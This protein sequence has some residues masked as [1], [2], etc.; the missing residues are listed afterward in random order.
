MAYYG[1]E[2]TKKKKSAALLLLIQL[3]E[4]H[5]Q[6]QQH[7]LHVNFCLIVFCKLGLDICTYSNLSRLMVIF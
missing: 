1:D 5:L 7:L 3:N 6:E 4:Q 2:S